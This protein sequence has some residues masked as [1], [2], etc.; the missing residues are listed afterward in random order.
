MFGLVTS[1]DFQK[2]GVSGFIEALSCA[3]P[4]LRGQ[5]R[6]LVMGKEKHLE[7]YRRQVVAEGLTDLVTFLP[8]STQVEK[9]Y[10]ALDVYVHPAHYEE[11]GQSVQEA[12]ACGLPVLTNKKVGAAELLSG[13]ALD[14]VPDRSEPQDLAGKM[15]VLAGDP[16]L[17]RRLSALGPRF[18]SGNTWNANFAATLTVYEGLLAEAKKG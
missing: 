17:R 18:V 5:L 16:S 3:A 8:P 12:L 14:Y 4:R 6:A 1:G 15:C 11:F 9:F 13:E 7:P 2:R 10:H